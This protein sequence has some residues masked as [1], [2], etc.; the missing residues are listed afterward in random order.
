RRGLATP[1]ASVRSRSGRSP[2]R[3]PPRRCVTRSLRRPPRVRLRRHRGRTPAGGRSHWNR[4]P[5]RPVAASSFARMPGTY[6]TEAVVLRSIR[7]G[8]A[9]RVLHLYSSSRGRIS[10]I[11]KGSR[12]PRSRFGGRL[13]P[14]FRLDLVLHE[15][16]GELAT[17]TA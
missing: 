5:V 12:R 10:A 16:R 15:G 7:Y 6:K 3:S 1:T 13:E 14:F 4:R 11:A 8:E 9:D 17:V 2:R